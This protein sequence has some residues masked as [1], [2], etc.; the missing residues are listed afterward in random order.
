MADFIDKFGAKTPVVFELSNGVTLESTIE[1]VSLLGT[2][3]AMIEDIGVEHP[4]PLNIEPVILK[5]VLEYAE[6]RVANPTPPKLLEREPGDPDPYDANRF[7]TVANT[8]FTKS[9][10]AASPRCVGNSP[11]LKTHPDGTEKPALYP[12]NLNSLMSTANYLDFTQLLFGV[13]RVIA[14]RLHGKTTAQ[15]RAEWDIINDFTPEEEAKAKAENEWIDEK[16]MPPIPTPEEVKARVLEAK[17]AVDKFMA[18]NKSNTSN[19]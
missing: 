10:D 15:M 6:Y 3:K 7:S 5:E 12:L 4:I 16:E 1:V 18:K 11:P 19:E 17:A 2:V 8:Q 14:K 13:G 9:A